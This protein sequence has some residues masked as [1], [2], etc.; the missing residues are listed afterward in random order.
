MYSFAHS[1]RALAILL[2]SHSCLAAADPLYRVIDLG[3]SQSQAL[4]INNQGDIVGGGSLGGR[5]SAFLQHQGTIQSLSQPGWGESE[6]TAVNELG[7]V[8]GGA[9]MGSGWHPFLY[10]AGKVTD[11]G[12]LGGHFG[13]DGFA[14]GIN[15][16]GQ[17][18]GWSNTGAEDPNRNPIYHA[19]IYENGTMTDIGAAFPGRSVANGINNNGQVVGWIEGRGAFL[20]Q[21]GIMQIIGSGTAQDINENGQIVYDPAVAINNLGQAVGYIRGSSQNR[22]ALFKDGQAID[23]NTLIEPGLGSILETAY[24]INDQGQIVARGMNG[25]E[26]R[27]FLL[28]PIP[29]PRTWLLLF[30]G[31]FALLYGRHARRSSASRPAKRAP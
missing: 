20:Y 21:N 16:K 25:G 23:L 7:Q 26:T 9:N 12:T 24:D 2:L 8:V 15:A 11:L 27:A 18:V 13:Y 4:G 31:S 28:E 14:A 10:N 5:Y 19:F 29:E 17:I 6:A 1:G 22:A 3:L 30:I